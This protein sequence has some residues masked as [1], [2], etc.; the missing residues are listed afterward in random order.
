LLAGGAGNDI[1]HECKWL[2]FNNLYLVIWLHNS[3]CWS[4]SWRFGARIPAS[5]LTINMF[6]NRNIQKHWRC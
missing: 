3:P 5:L 6:R 1:L 4:A 2:T